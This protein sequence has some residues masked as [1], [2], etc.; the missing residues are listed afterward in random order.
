MFREEAVKVNTALIGST[1]LI[2]V[3]GV[4]TATG[5][6]LYLFLFCTVSDLVYLIMLSLGYITHMNEMFYKMFPVFRRV[7][8]LPKTCVGGMMGI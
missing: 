1:Q 3:E 2:L 5:C 7:K 4:S 6:H 8:G